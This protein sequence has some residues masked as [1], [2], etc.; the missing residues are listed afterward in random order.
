MQSCTSFL[1]LLSYSCFLTFYC[2]P[3]FF[4]KFFNNRLFIIGTDKDIYTTTGFIIP[5]K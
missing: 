1:A 5:T 2:D 3:Y 4:F